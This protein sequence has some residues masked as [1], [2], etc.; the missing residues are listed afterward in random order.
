MEYIL[1]TG[2]LLLQYGDVWTTYRL[3]ERGGREL[4]PIV[5]WPIKRLGLLPG[6]LAVKLPICAALIAATFAGMMPAWL[7]TALCALYLVVVTQNILQL[8]S[9]A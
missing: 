5:A 9:Q 8:E 3:L 1:L 6:L 7:L 4:N 2:L